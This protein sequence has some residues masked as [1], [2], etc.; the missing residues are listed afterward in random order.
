MPVNIIAKPE[1]RGRVVLKRKR[2]KESSYRYKR[3]PFLVQQNVEYAEKCNPQVNAEAEYILPAS[4]QT[5]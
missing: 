3:L 1:K 2:G 5:I 4:P